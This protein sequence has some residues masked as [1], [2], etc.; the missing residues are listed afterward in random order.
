MA[1]QFNPSDF[2][3]L[4][5]LTDKEW[6]TIHCDYAQVEY[7][8]FRFHREGIVRGSRITLDNQSRNSLE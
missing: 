4:E 8:L 1:H 6:R 2:V 5:V 3:K 7:K